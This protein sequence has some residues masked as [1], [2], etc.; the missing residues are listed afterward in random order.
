[1]HLKKLLYGYIIIT[2]IV[3]FDILKY[4]GA[5]TYTQKHYFLILSNICKM[6]LTRDLI[7]MF[8]GVSFFHQTWGVFF[9]S[10]VIKIKNQN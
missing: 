8:V 6:F 5:G 3:D 7:F 4:L 9:Q 1:M 2:T 10:T